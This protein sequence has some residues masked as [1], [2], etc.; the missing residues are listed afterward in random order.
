MVL[1][2]AQNTPALIS[3]DTL[4]NGDEKAVKC[5]SLSQI[6]C[7]LQVIKL[8]HH[9]RAGASVDCLLIIFCL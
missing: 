6:N 9:S 3:L 5:T 4:E 8:I 2:A 7:F 1:L